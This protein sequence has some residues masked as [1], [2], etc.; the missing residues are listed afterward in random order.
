MSTAASFPHVKVA[1][2]LLC[3]NNRDLLEQFLPEIIAYTPDSG[4]YGIFVI[5]NASTDGTSGYLETV[6]K[7]VNVITIAVNKG[8]TNGY[9]LGLARIDAEIFCLLSSDVQI[10]EGWLEPVTTLFDSDSDIAVVQ[11]KVRSWHDKDRFEYAGASGGFI[12]SLGFP[13][14]RGRIFYDTEEDEGQYDDVRE[15]FWASGA[16]FFIRSEVYRVSGGL[17]DDFYA[18][19]E[20]IDLCWRIKNMGHKVMVCPSS[21]VYHIGGAVIAYGSPEKTFRNHRNNLIMLVKNLPTRELIPKLMARLLLDA[22][23][24]ANMIFRGQVRASFSIVTAHW[25]F[26]FKLRRWLRKR[27]A[28]TKGSLNASTSGVYPDS[29]IKAYFIQGKKKFSELRW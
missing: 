15:I 29:L 3:Y 16:C 13:F 14:C 27:N 11:P 1:I 4:D 23:A 18:H 6:G 7:E 10:S 9:K 24:F 17:D 21:I 2:A 5:D 25:S 20:E 8:F 22:L 12:D 26:L 19:M 28:L